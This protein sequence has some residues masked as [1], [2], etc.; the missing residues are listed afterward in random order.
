MPAPAGNLVS[1]KPFSEAYMFYLQL[2]TPLL[3]GTASLHQADERRQCG[4]NG[5]ETL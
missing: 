3:S 1:G 5:D 2:G 4:G